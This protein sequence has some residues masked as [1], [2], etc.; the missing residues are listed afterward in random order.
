MATSIHQF[1]F[2]PSTAH[3]TLK[4]TQRNSR[5]KFPRKSIKAPSLKEICQRGSLREA[6]E[7]LSNSFTE[8]NPPH[9]YLDEAYSLVLELC[10]SKKALSQ[11]EQIH[12]HIIKSNAVYD[13]VFLS[14]KLVFMYG[15][16]G[17]ISNAEELFDRM[18]ERTIFTWNAMIGAYVT[19]GEPL[20]ALGLF[21]EM[22]VS[23][24]PPDARTFPCILKACG[25]LNDLHC[26]TVIHGL[27]I[28]LGFVSN[29]FVINS[30]VDMYVKCNDL[31]EAMQL[32]DRRSER[33]DVVSWNSI[34]SA[35]SANGQSMEAL[36]LFRE[37]QEAGLTPSTYTFVAVLQA[38]EEPSFGKFGKEIH[39]TILKSSHY[40][41]VYV[42]NA[43]LVM[44]SKCGKIVEA[45]RIFNG[46]DEKDN[47]SWNSMLSGFV[48]NGLCNDALQF[49][50]K[51]LDAGK[52]PDKISV[53]GNTFIDMYAKCSRMSY[54]S[55]VFDRIPNKDFISWTTAI[56]GYAQNNCHMRALQLFQEVQ[57][58]VKDIVSWTSMIS[59]YVRNGLAN[60]ALGLFLSIKEMGIEPDSIAL[61]SI[62]S[63]VASLSALRKG[64]EIHGFLVRKG[65][66]PGGSAASSLVDMY[67]RC[68]SLDNSYKVFNYVRDKDLVM[69][70][71]M[72]NAYG[73]HGCGKEAIDLF[74]RMED[75]NLVP[76]HVT[77]LALLYACSHSGLVDEGAR[78]FEIMKCEYQL[79]PWS[80]HY[81]CLVDL[82]GRANHLEEAFQFVK[83][84]H[85]EPT[86]AVWCALLGACRVHSNKK[87]GEIAA[88][89]L[90]ELDPENPGFYVLVSN[91]FAAT[92][93]WED[94]EEVRMRMKGK[95]LKKD[96]AC[97]WIEVGNKVHTFIARDRSHPQSDEIYQKLAQITEILEK[98][99]GYVAQ[100]KFVLHNVEEEEKIKMLYGHSERLAIAYS[101]LATT[102]GTPI[103]ITKNL[104]VC[105]DCHTFS[106][107]VS[108]G[109]RD[110]KHHLVLHGK[111]VMKKARG[112]C[113]APF[114]KEEKKNRGEREE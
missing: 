77:F 46:M 87:L 33:E 60:E 9:F 29:V 50:H 78:I 67:A 55:S 42:V 8:Q 25:G 61:V 12:A 92:G 105:G 107:L 88:Q 27:T 99:G 108:R 74:R 48:Q 97:S 36:R 98:E 37:M 103:R 83:G 5:L 45:A 49:Y 94:V 76:D 26:G 85:T 30:L 28:K 89:K 68:G 72:I 3:P 63:A 93:K 110:P 44:Y 7:S 31:C 91:V 70:T 111:E 19:N 104:R 17:S 71:S 32:F 109:Q 24:V 113:F 65:F 112:K 15:K 106:K 22:H 6:F 81:A 41:D 14:T 10:A 54:M 53:V 13:S 52:K 66:I 90:L 2:N 11:G 40:F 18:C 39:A 102:E 114:L 34:I 101:L 47:V 59:C 82:L 75:E 86:A 62:L 23:G 38:C 96:P 16:C 20:G 100:T 35:F 69:W 51:M 80:E 1:F 58:E 84:M 95:G 73:M 21:S 57:M 64:K 79:E 4:K 56:A 43:L